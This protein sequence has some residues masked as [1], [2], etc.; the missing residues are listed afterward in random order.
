MVDNEDIG[1]NME[2][3]DIIRLFGSQEEETLDYIS[4]I[5]IEMASRISAKYLEELKDLDCEIKNDQLN[6]IIKDFKNIQKSV[7]RARVRIHSMRK[8]LYLSKNTRLTCPIRIPKNHSQEG[9]N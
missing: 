3:E 8:D 1:S 2:I 6:G 9:E 7:N 4:V 5:A